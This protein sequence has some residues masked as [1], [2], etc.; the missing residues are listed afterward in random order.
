MLY[1][2]CDYCT[3]HDI[4][5]MYGYDQVWADHGCCITQT[6]NH[7]ASADCFCSSIQFFYLCCTLSNIN[8]QLCNGIILLL[9]FL[10][11]IGNLPST[12]FQQCVHIAESLEELFVCERGKLDMRLGMRLG[13]Y[14]AA[15]AAW[16][17]C[18][19]RACDWCWGWGCS[20][21]L[22]RSGYWG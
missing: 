5:D 13:R 6:I 18:G 21:A 16:R 14:R 10:L 17:C 12:G 19:N 2:V 20:S 8:E 4:Q 22:Q 11:L 3:S 7:M 15:A 1:M 9:N